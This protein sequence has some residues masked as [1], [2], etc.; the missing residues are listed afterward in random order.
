MLRKLIIT[1]MIMIIS[2]NSILLPGCQTQAQTGALIGGLGG[3]GIGAAVEGTE[4]AL[5]GGAIG[6]G[7]GYIIGNEADKK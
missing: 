3:A 4:G 6:A 5:I 2:L 1:L 7:A